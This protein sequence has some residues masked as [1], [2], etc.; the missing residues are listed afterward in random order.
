MGAA[1]SPEQIIL[2]NDRE[3]ALRCVIV[4]DHTGLGPGLGGT[5]I[6]DYPDEAAAV[7]DAV[8]LAQAMTYKAALA[9]LP[10]GGAKAVIIGTPPT[11][12]R[13]RR[14][15]AFGRFVDSL[16]G[17]YIA[18]QDSGT[19]VSDMDVIRSQTPHVVGVSEMLG[20]SGDPSPHTAYG[21]YQA[22]RACA[23]VALGTRDL[24]GLRV[25][26]I[27]VGSVGLQLARLLCDAGAEVSVADVSA[28]AAQRA[29][30]ELGVRT[31]SPTTAIE[32]ET[33]ILAPCALGGVVSTETVRRLRC[34]AIVGAANNQL[35]DPAL[36]LELAAM[37]IS[38]VPDFLANAGGVI[39]GS[40]EARGRVEREDLKNAVEQVYRATRDVLDEAAITG[41]PPL[42]VALEVAGR[43]LRGAE[44]ANAMGRRQTGSD[45]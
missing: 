45:E 32:T 37:E 21:V 23:E 17:R 42:T 6:R 12:L 25:T 36:A 10:F 8:Q 2:C 20:G 35:T 30:A 14:L 39:V 41:R 18:A 13:E 24:T 27:G 29:V 43:R 28:A 34:R 1:A 31:L 26:V 38:Y 9:D 5:R 22:M 3:S 44:V 40:H 16:G 7:Q 11:Q 15:Q 4:I 19:F 33:D